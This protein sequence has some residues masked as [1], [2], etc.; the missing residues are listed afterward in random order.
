MNKMGLPLWRD[1]QELSERQECVFVRVFVLGS[2]SAF[3][4]TE[5]TLR[6]ELG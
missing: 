1:L 4:R 2:M 5:A 6:T 3:E